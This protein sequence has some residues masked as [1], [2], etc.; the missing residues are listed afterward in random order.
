MG[1]T[2]T[3]WFTKRPRTTT[4]ASSKKPSTRGSPWLCGQVGAD[5][6]RTAPAPRRPGRPRGRPPPRGARSRR[7]RVG[8][9][10]G[11][12]LG[13]GH[14]H[15][16]TGSPTKRTLL[17]GQRGG[18]CRPVTPRRSRGA[19]PGRG[20][21][22]CRRRPRRAWPRPRRRRCE[23]MVAWATGER[24]K[25]EVEQPGQPQVGEVGAPAGEEV[26]VLDTADGVTEDRSGHGAEPSGRRR[27][28]PWRWRA[29]RWWG[30]GRRGRWRPCRAR[31]C[32]APGPRPCRP[33]PTGSA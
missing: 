25:D 16:H 19:Q 2:A 3:R 32:P 30:R 8:G 27:R 29:C 18:A 15:G 21:R 9:V 26:G 23:L 6:R 33:G 22:R 17:D 5:A 11:L 12:G 20:R 24:T 7:P 4:S 14:D 31:G 13:L 10:D 1:T 28:R